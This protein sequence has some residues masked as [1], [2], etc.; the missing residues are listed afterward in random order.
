MHALAFCTAI[1][2]SQPVSNVNSH[3]L[4]YMNIL[5]SFSTGNVVGLFEVVKS[6][7][8][9]VS[10]HSIKYFYTPIKS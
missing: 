5:G 10:V 9:N 2:H 8:K 3:L 4:V 1:S 6:A 7:Q